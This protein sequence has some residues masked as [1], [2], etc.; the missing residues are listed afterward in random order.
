MLEVIVCEHRHDCTRD[1]G[2]G[3]AGAR[4][5]RVFFFIGACN[6]PAVLWKKQIITN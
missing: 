6:V 3:G 2:V 5:S 1:V 4:K